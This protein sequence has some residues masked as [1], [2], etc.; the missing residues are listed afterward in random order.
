M[1]VLV[2]L[3]DRAG[4]GLPC[5]TSHAEQNHFYGAILP[6]IRVPA[7]GWT[8]DFGSVSKELHD[9]GN[10]TNMTIITASTTESY[11]VS[12]TLVIITFIHLFNPPNKSERYTVV[13]FPFYS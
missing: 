9:F 8:L 12:G 1:P 4:G 7:V 6:S 13:L 11:Y 10:N 2:W 5:S 3:R